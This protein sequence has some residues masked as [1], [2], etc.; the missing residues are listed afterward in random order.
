MP[1]EGMAMATVLMIGS[2]IF[3]QWTT[4]ARAFPSHQV[5]N[6]AVGGTTTDHWLSHSQAAL[7]AVDPDVV[8][9]LWQQ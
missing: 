2:S 5:F 4:A 1:Y 3:A 6:Q 8:L 7:A 9:L